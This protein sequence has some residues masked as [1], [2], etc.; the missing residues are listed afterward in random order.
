VQKFTLNLEDNIFTLHKKLRS[1]TYRHSNYTSFYI[2]DPKLRHIHKATVSDRII[3][4]AIMRVI[5]PLFDRAFIFD[6]YSSRKNKGMHRAIKRF[7]KLAWKLSC[8]NTKL[9]WVLKCDIKKFFDSIDHNILLTLIKKKIND[10]KMIKLIEN[11]IRSFSDEKGRG[12]PLGNL[13]SQ[14]FSNIYL[15]ELDQFVKQ[16]LRASYYIR[17]A[18]DFVILSRDKAYLQN[19]LVCIDKFLCEK[20]QL[21]LHKRKVSIRQWH[22]GIDFLGYVIFQYH[23]ILRTKT[24]RRI[25]KKVRNK[26]RVMVEGKIGEDKFKQTLQSYFGI[27][28]HCSGNKIRN[29]LSNCV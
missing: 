16:N 23:I 18:D 20:L 24:K 22:K 25:L 5:E 29:L 14:L 21:Q 2:R 28:K 13:T 8:N 4:H 1:E 17:Y 9:V 27:L 12:I 6:S 7:K 26:K 15:N 10:E 19:L 3:H 11:I